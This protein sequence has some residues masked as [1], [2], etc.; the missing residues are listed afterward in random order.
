MGAGLFTEKS[1]RIRKER[2][3]LPDEAISR[4]LRNI[5]ILWKWNTSFGH[6][7]K[8]HLN[9]T[10]QF[11]GLC[12]NH[13]E[14][15]SS[16]PCVRELCDSLRTVWM[17]WQ[18]S[19]AWMVQMDSQNHIRFRWRLWIIQCSNDG[20]CVQEFWHLVSAFITIDIYYP[21]NTWLQ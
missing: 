15:L 18:Q 17:R 9:G 6:G 10:G 4:I 2:A 7:W 11:V 3:G 21:C 1:V 5:F 20:T 8:A 19:R 13:I 14:A 12:R 16:F